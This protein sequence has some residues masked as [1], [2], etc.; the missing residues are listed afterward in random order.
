MVKAHKWPTTQPW[1]VIVVLVPKRTFPKMQAK[2]IKF[3][4]FLHRL[5]FMTFLCFH[6]NFILLNYQNSQNC[7]NLTSCHNLNSRLLHF[8]WIDSL[9]NYLYFHM[10]ILTCITSLTKY[11]SWQGM[12]NLNIMIFHQISNLHFIFILT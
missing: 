6:V 5:N 3:F 12:E 4:V 10:H 1:L 11:S 8:S 7:V 9:Q 2:Q